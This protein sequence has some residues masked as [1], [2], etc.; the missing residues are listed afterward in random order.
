MA[1]CCRLNRGPE[2]GSLEFGFVDAF[3]CVERI[4]IL[5]TIQIQTA[6]NLLQ[7]NTI[8]KLFKRIELIVSECFRC[9]E[10]K[11]LFCGGRKSNSNVSKQGVPLRHF[12]SNKLTFF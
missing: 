8:C 7:R 11:L 1:I 2:L 9:S 5:I 10:R 3:L 4:S 12:I 6:F